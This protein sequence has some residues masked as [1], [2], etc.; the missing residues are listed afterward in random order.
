[1]VDQRLLPYPYNQSQQAQST[2]GQKGC[3]SPQSAQPTGQH[4]Q[5]QQPQPCQLPQ[6]HPHPHTHHMQ[7]PVQSQAMHLHMQNMQNLR[8]TQ[9]FQLQHQRQGCQVQ[10]NQ[11]HSSAVETQGPVNSQ[12]VQEQDT[13]AQ[14]S[15]QADEQPAQQEQQNQSLPQLQQISQS[16]ASDLGL[17]NVSGF[18]SSLSDASFVQQDLKKDLGSIISS[19]KSHKIKVSPV[20]REECLGTFLLDCVYTGLKLSNRKPCCFMKY[21]TCLRQTLYKFTHGFLC[22]CSFPRN[23]MIVFRW[24][25][26]T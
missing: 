18:S 9:N 22:K 1:M 23:V 25:I 26:Q 8:K 15:C 3:S 21:L 13:Q 2:D 19:S 4:Q 7:T 5:M 10:S 24:Y 17:Y 20:Q 12:S 16:L 6:R 11:C 14:V